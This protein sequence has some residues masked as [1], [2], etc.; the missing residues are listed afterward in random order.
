MDIRSAVFE[1]LDNAA[2]NGFD[3]KEY[4]NGVIIQDLLDCDADLEDL[5]FDALLPHVRAWK[6]AH[7]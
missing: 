3:M 2:K 7:A 5:P 6:K 4:E 1:A